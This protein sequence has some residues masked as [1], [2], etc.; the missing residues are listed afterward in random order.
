[1]CPPPVRLLEPVIVSAARLRRRRSP[2]VPESAPL[3]KRPAPSIV[4]PVA[5]AHRYETAR[6]G[7]RYSAERYR[8]PTGPHSCFARQPEEIATGEAAHSDRRRC[9]PRTSAGAAATRWRRHA[10]RDPGSPTKYRK[11]K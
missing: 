1:M 4:P 8:K 7:L 5:L 6:Q 3:L 2:P 9:V 11:N 10:R